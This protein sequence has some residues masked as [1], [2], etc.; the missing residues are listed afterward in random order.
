MWKDKIT[1]HFLFQPHPSNV[2]SISLTAAALILPFIF[3]LQYLNYLTILYTITE[4]SDTFASFPKWQILPRK[5][6][7]VCHLTGLATQTILT[8]YKRSFLHSDYRSY[9]QLSPCRHFTITSIIRTAAKSL[10][11]INNGRLTE[12]NCRCY[13]LSLLRTLTRGPEGVRHKES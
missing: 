13:G 8:E 6:K 4:Q 10:A 12:I 2:K 7:D 5:S 9:S 11:K 1:V 3:F